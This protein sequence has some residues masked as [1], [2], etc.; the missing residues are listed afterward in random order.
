MPPEI[1]K[2]PFGHIADILA[3]HPDSAA[4]R[5]KQP[6]SQLHDDSLARAGYTPEDFRFALLNFERN[7]AENV[8]LA[9]IDVDILEDNERFARNQFL[10]RRHQR[11]C[12]TR[13]NMKGL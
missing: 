12:E 2:V 9:K 13:R 7:S 4:V 10:H 3:H 8:V 11:H 1:E 5:T 6:G